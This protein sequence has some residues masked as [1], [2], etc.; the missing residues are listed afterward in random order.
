[1]CYSCKNHMLYATISDISKAIQELS[2]HFKSLMMVLTYWRSVN[3]RRIKSKR[4]LYLC[5]HH[6]NHDWLYHSRC[7]ATSNSPWSRDRSIHSWSRA[8]W[9][10]HLQSML[11]SR[12]REDISWS[13]TQS[14][15]WS[16]AT[17][18]HLK[19]PLLHAL[20]V[21]QVKLLMILNHGVGA[22]C[23]WNICRNHSCTWCAIRH[24]WLS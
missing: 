21:E 18:S 24:S 7:R 3:P 8:S 5:L 15:S 2:K 10:S 16:R 4:N 20:G 6:Q 12:S 13:L 17:K 23:H 14:H 1:M 11:C 9:V 19:A 22:I